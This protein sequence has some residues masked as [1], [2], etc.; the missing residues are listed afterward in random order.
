MC[1]HPITIHTIEVIALSMNVEFSYGLLLCS[2]AFKEVHF[3]S[4]Y[5]VLLCLS[6]HDFTMHPCYL[7]R[8]PQSFYLC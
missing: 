2:V 5:G 6:L 3:A 7:M 8:L 4:Q 1:S